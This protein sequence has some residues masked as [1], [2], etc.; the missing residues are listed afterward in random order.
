MKRGPRKRGNMKEKRWTDKDRGK[1]EV[2][3]VE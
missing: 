2:K 1:I 3:W